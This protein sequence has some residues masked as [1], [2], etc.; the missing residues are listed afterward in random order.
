M[1]IVESHKRSIAKAVSWRIFASV[2][3][4][5]VVYIFTRELVLSA[6]I[7]IVDMIIKI[8]GYYSHE[9]IW[10]KI[11]FGRKEIKEDYMI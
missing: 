6:G 10:E 3:T 7:G 8:L 2:V 1:A 5:I 9:R 4:V 11:R